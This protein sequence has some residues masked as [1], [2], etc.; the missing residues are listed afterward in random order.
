MQL[1]RSWLVSG[2]GSDH[3]PLLVDFGIATPSSPEP[4]SVPKSHE[5]QVLEALHRLEMRLWQL[6]QLQKG[7]EASELQVYLLSS[8]LASML[9]A[10][11][12]AWLGT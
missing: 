6:E 4:I 11:A 2:L 8:S 1:K 10:A 7:A 3:L 9:V 5:N 12:A